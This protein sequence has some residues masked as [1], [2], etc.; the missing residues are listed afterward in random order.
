MRPPSAIETRFG[1][2]GVQR[3]ARPS[4]LRFLIWLGNLAGLLLEGSQVGRAIP[5][6]PSR[7]RT[8]RRLARAAGEPLKGIISGLTGDLA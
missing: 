4:I 7:R 2:S 8:K 5:Y 3:T 1:S 6:G